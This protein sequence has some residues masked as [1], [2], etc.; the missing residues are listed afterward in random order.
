[1]LGKKRK[2]KEK[3]KRKK[4]AAA[5][6]AAIRKSNISNVTNKAAFQWEAIIHNTKCLM[7]L[8]KS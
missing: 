2:K 4:K 7:W 6:F 5:V 3:R 8:S 1:M